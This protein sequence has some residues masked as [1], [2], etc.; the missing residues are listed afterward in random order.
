MER[1]KPISFVEMQLLYLRQEFLKP[2]PFDP[3]M[4]DKTMLVIKPTDGISRG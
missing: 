1:D 3:K 2:Q 4:P